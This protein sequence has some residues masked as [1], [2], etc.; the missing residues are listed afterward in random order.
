MKK[1]NFK[2]YII[3]L[4]LTITVFG[5]AFVISEYI[6]KRKTNELKAIEDKISI[7]ILS[8][9]TQFDI[10]EES[11][12]KEFDRS[13][14]RTELSS[15]SSKL[16]FLEGQLG[17]NDP[18]VFRLKRYYSLLQIRDYLL[19]K[20]MNDECDYGK[21]FILYFYSN[22]NCATCQTQ[23]YILRAIQ[24]EYP[25]IEIYTFDYD[26]DLPAVKTLISQHNVPNALPIIDINGKN[27]AAFD[28]LASMESV[29]QPFLEQATSTTMT[30]TS[31]TATSTS[32]KNQ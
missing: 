6:N 11:S 12:C 27:Y 4:F 19:T 2:I 23:E 14:L 3:A 21:V 24:N 30:A 18:E 26:I 28:S 16:D 22:K 1:I 17:E 9:E 29:I 32:K 10:I 20:R 15:L 8:F 31:S 25:Q 7:D 5:V 13:T